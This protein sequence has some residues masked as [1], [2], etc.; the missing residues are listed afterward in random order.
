[1][2]P[3]TI[4]ESVAKNLNKKYKLDDVLFTLGN[5]AP[6]CWRNAKVFGGENRNLSHFYNSSFGKKNEDYD[7]FYE[8]YKDKMNN[9]MYLGYLTHLIT[10]TYWRNYVYPKYITKVNGNHAFIKK[11][12]SI[13]YTENKEEFSKFKWKN[14]H[15]MDLPLIEKY[16]LIPLPIEIIEYNNFDFNIDELDLTGLFGNEG[17]INYTNNVIDNAEYYE[18]D[19]FDIEKIAEDIDKT[20]EFID[21]EIDRLSSK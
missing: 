18:S 15:S 13:Y 3:F 6:D 8:K 19:L 14:I 4:H 16:N 2:P 7:T 17:T 12:G 20:C 5:I 11:D 1:M 21:K 10:D 9:P